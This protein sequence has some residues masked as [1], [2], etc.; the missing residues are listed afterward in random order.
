MLK[1]FQSLDLTAAQSAPR[2]V[3]HTLARGHASRA[4]SVVSAVVYLGESP[5][6]TA[7]GRDL[8]SPQ[9]DSLE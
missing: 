3:K 1:Q 4:L 6:G 9:A 5:N 2:S 8:P 7:G